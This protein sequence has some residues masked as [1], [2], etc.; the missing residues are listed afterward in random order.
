[1]A[2]TLLLKNNNSFLIRLLQPTDSDALYQY[3]SVSLSGVSKRRYGPHPFDKET[4]D[5]ICAGL[6][7]DTRRYIAIGSNNRITAYMLIKKGM[8]DD[9]R[10]RLQM[11][12]M[13]YDLEKVC[14][15]APSVADAFQNSGLGSSM[16]DYIEKDIIENTS[17]QYILLWG[18]V[19]TANDIAVHFYEKKGFQHIGTFWHDGKDNYDMIK[20]V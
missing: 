7:G 18:G 20:K 15:F 4:I 8:T 13:Y 9:D 16:Y 1:M 5:S 2:I 12:N 10:A 19:Q 11:K 14:T 17:C 3:L 6:P